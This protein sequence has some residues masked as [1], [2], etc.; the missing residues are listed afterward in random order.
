MLPRVSVVRQP[1]ALI[2][3][4]GDLVGGWVSWEVDNNN[5]YSA[6]T[7]RVSFA[8]SQLPK[9]YSAAFWANQSTDIFV[10]ILAGFPANPNS[11]QP[12]ELENLIYG[13]VDSIEYSLERAEITVTGRDLTALFIDDRTTQKWEELTSSQIAT[14]LA[15]RHKLGTSYITATNGIVGAYY[16][17]KHVQPT[18][19]RSE[20][21]LLANLAT[22]EGFELYVKGTDLHFEP[23]PDP[24][25]RKVYQ[26][27]WTPPSDGNAASTFNGISLNFSRAM[28]V[29]RGMQVSVRS[30]NQS[31]KIGFTKTYPSAIGSRGTQAG[32]SS[33]FGGVQT[34]SYVVANLTPEQAQKYAQ[35]K[36]NELIQNEM[37]LVARLPADGNI[38]VNDILLVAGTGTAYDQKYYPDSIVRQMSLTEGYVMIINAKNHATDSAP[39]L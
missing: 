37:K 6:D 31:Q 33:P 10:E 29:G 14:L 4:N 24:T 12:S 23:T 20:W 3:V 28:T 2:R 39:V 13:R 11:P 9:D 25:Q 22:V 26:L 1:R 27:A 32:K 30:W 15:T 5:Y 17:Y 35:N 38:H 21:D 16:K 7:F 19:M 18:D 8:T 36:Y 34:Y